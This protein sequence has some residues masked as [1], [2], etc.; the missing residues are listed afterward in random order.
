[1]KNDVRSK[2][3]NSMA[4]FKSTVRG[5]S[6][7]DPPWGHVDQPWRLKLKGWNNVTEKVYKFSSDHR[8]PTTPDYT[9]YTIPVN[10]LSHHRITVWLSYYRLST[11]W[12]YS[13]IS[14][15]GLK[16][17]VQHDLDGIFAHYLENSTCIL[18]T[19]TVE[20]TWHHS[21]H[22]VGAGPVVSP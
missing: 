22:G 2:D 19:L 17:L 13:D 1:M 14:L 16:W 12:I 5:E 18:W 11:L 3:A 9:L 4:S 6:S 7:D 8:P 10:L 15:C 21:N 20:S